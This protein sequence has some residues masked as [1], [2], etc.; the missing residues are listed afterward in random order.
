MRRVVLVPGDGIGPEITDA[1]MKVIEALGVEID[2]QIVEAGAKT[3]EEYG[4]P[5]SPKFFPLAWECGVV[6]RGPISSPLEKG[7]RSVNTIIKERLNLYAS[8]RFAKSIPGVESLRDDVD[9]VIVRENTEGIYVGFEREAAQGVVESI[10]LTT[11]SA[12]R[13]IARFAF[14]LASKTGRKKVT[15]LH[16]ANVLKMGDGLFVS[17]VENV[18]KGYTGLEFEEMLIDS[19]CRQMV[20]DPK[21]FDVV[22]AQNLYGD[23]VTDLV[24][25]LVGGLA[26][27]PAANIGNDIAV[28]EAAHGPELEIAGKGIANPS[29]LMLSAAWMLE[30]IG[31]QEA[32]ERMK[33]AVYATLAEKE[34]L[35]PDMGGNSDTERFT[36]AVIDAL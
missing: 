3:M 28:F 2:W 30:H 21:S 13:R 29:G 5:L 24:A 33:N 4:R 8:V 23:I 6:L 31:F 1:T 19:A 11:E 7:R 16:K 36:R 14:E 17:T 32:G 18:S 15:A 35:T 12:S 22:V 26:L 20:M 25:G 9:M 34:F 10:K 27:M